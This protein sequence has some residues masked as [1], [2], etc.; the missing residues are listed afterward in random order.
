MKKILVPFIAALALGAPQAAT[1]DTAV[2]TAAPLCENGSVLPVAVG[3][4]CYG[5][6]KVCT[7]YVRVDLESVDG[8]REVICV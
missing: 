5:G 8:T 3:V 6:G 4:R 1:A 7:V 2:T